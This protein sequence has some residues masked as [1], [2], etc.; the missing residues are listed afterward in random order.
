M[1]QQ[2]SAG[3]LSEALHAEAEE[4]TPRV[5]TARQAGRKKMKLQSFANSSNPG[6][7]LIL[8]DFG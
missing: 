7:M 4:F 3:G 5:Q 6:G 2:I 1:G 8:S